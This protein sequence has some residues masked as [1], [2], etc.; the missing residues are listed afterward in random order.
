MFEEKLPDTTPAENTPTPPATTP[1]AETEEFETILTGHDPK[2]REVLLLS[3]GEVYK[4]TKV[5]TCFESIEFTSHEK[6]VT[7]FEHKID[8]SQN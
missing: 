6:A 3:N 2:N 5:D 1:E 7:L 4:V 8:C